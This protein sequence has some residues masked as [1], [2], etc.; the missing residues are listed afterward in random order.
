MNLKGLYKKLDE[1]AHVF[2]RRQGCNSTAKH[3]YK[4]LRE[5]NIP[6]KHLT[7]QQKNQIKKV[8]GDWI[9]SDCFATH[10]LVLSVTGE[11]DPYICPEMVFRT[12]LELQLNN[13]QL[14]WG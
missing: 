12:N 9:R 2:A 1:K 6:I 7:S 11:F 3:Y 10:E 8:W 5:H 4:M 14:K 13:F